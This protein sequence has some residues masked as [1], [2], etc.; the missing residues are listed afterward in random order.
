MSDEALL[1]ARGLFWAFSAGV[2]FLPMRWAIF[3]LILASHM[4]ITFLSFSSATTVGFENTVRIAM[5]PLVLLVRM[6]FVPLRNLHWKLPH[7]LWLALTIYAGIAGIWGGF[8]LSSVKLVAYLAAYLVLF[9]ILCA[10]WEARWIDLGLLRLACWCVMGLAIVQTY[11]QGNGWGGPEARFTSFS[12]PQYFAAFLVAMLAIFVFSGERGFLHYT[13]C[14]VLVVAIVFCG[15]RYVFVSMVLLLLGASL[16][17]SS[18]GEEYTR[19]RLN[20]RRV[21]V[22]LGL[23]AAGA[24]ALLAYL[25]DNRIDELVTDVSDHGTNVDD[26]ATLAWRLGIYEQILIRVDNRK[27]S[28]L[29]FGSGTGSGAALLLDIDPTHYNPD[30]ID[31]NRSLHSEYLRALY[32]WGILGLALLLAFLIATTIGFTRKITAE[33]GGPAVAFLGVL[34]SIL[35]GLAI[36][37]VLAGAVS[38]A[39]VGILLCMSFAWQMQPEPPVEP[40]PIAELSSDSPVL[41]A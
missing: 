33:G 20:F 26:V 39:G 30:D 25:P 8:P 7:K 13:T 36:E 28:D 2:V 40:V 37:N 4:D 27:P 35:I 29:F 15:S 21:L 16:R 5:L 38:A 24:S 23:V 3:C 6:Q 22:T 9:S 11:G 17:V 32:E 1:I 19:F 18:A 34:P 41:S 12:T 31:A 14:A 10:A